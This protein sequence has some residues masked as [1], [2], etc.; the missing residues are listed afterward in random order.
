MGGTAEDLYNEGIRHS[1]KYW[2]GLPD[3]EIDDYI[4]STNTPAAVQ[5]G[6]VARDFNS[7]PQ[8]DITVKY[9]EGGSFER[10]LEQII[11][12][13]WIDL[14]MSPWECWAERRRT[15]YPKGYA[16]IESLDPGI[17]VTAII[18]RMVFPPSE[19]SNNRV[20]VEKAVTL[21]GGDDNTMTRLW[22]DKKPLSDYPDLS[23]TIVP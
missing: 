13:K 12:Q 18:R 15:G 8:S 11:T 10:Q 17:P 19:Y 20:A 5:D 14:F 3:N 4:A 2:A 21:L 9:D 6:I 1:L 23:A 16:I 22:W 7:P